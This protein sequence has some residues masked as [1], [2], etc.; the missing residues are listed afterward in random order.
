MT[1]TWSWSWPPRRTRRASARRKPSRRHSTPS[2]RKLSK[3]KYE[4]GWTGCCQISWMIP[5]F[6]LSKCKIDILKIG[7]KK[8]QDTGYLPKHR[9]G[10]RISGLRITVCRFLSLISE[11]S[12]T[13][14]D[15]RNFGYWIWYNNRLENRLDTN[16]KLHFN[17]YSFRCPKKKC[18]LRG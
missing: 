10:Y 13:E 17:S 12:D 5:D 9:A 3:C 16:F 1:R 15:F 7:Q 18:P 14:F 6:R 11:I 4:W 8:R 2:G